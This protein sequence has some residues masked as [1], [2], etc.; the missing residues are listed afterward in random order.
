VEYTVNR[1]HNGFFGHKN[2]DQLIAEQGTQPLQSIESLRG[3]FWPEEE[4]SDEFIAQLRI[5]RDE[6]HESE[7]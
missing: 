3:D 1:G 2:L 6:Q 4:S 5:W 7:L